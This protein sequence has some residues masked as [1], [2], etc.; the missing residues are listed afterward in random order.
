MQLA[1]EIK[2]LI[3]DSLSLEDITVEDI[4]NDTLLFDEQGLGLDSVDALELGL[5]LQKKY[6]FSFDVEQHDLNTYFKSVQ[7]LTDF[8]QEQINNK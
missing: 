2:K 5:E 6:G 7:T 8:V 3:I 1:D 4:S